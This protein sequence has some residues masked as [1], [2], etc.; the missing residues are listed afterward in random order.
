M[1]ISIEN[2]ILANGNN[3][4]EEPRE[5]RIQGSKELQISPLLRSRS[6]MIYDRGNTKVTITFRVSRQHSNADEAL[7]NTMTHT[8]TVTSIH[9]N[10]TF[11]LEDDAKTIFHL[12]NASVRLVSSQIIGVTSSHTYEIVGSSILNNNQNNNQS[13]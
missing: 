12:T 10:A 8:G 2:I 7:I 4:C 9:G 11:E 5:L 13:Q 3:T 6:V 1:K